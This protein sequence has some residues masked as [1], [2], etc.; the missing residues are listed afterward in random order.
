MTLTD[1]NSS[2]KQHEEE[3]KSH[4]T[5]HLTWAEAAKKRLNTSVFGSHIMIEKYFYS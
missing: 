2:N 4:T 5:T 3:S 1:R